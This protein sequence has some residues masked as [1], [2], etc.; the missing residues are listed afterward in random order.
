MRVTEFSGLSPLC[1]SCHRDIHQGQFAEGS[2]TECGRC[3][4]PDNWTSL[5][6]DHD[7]LSA[8][9]LRGAHKNVACNSCHR[10]EQSGQTRFVRF[11]PLRR[12]CA[13]CHSQGEKK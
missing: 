12:T 9:P 7:T 3:H 5:S 4:T 1:A 11:R 8:F 2:I 13:A 10:E 6:F